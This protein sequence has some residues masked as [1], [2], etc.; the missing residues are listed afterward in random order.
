MLQN[1]NK[2]DLRLFAIYYR[3]IEEHTEQ[4]KNIIRQCKSERLNR[5]FIACWCINQNRNACMQ[6]QEKSSR[7]ASSVVEEVF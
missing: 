5:E 6:S 4:Q 2:Y 1:K 3:K 7:I